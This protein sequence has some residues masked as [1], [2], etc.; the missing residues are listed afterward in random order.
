MD[1]TSIPNVAIVIAN[2]NTAH[3]VTDAIES[4]LTQD[5]PA[6]GIFIV[7]D[8]SSDESLKIIK[9]FLYKN[10]PVGIV[11][12]SGPLMEENE[13]Y[14]LQ[15][16]YLKNCRAYLFALK[17][18]VGRGQ[19][20][21]FPIAWALNNGY[22]LIQILDSDDIMMENKVSTLVKVMLNDP[23]HIG[24]VYADYFIYN[25]DN[26]VTTYE[27]KES[28]DYF[29]FYSGKDM[30]HSSSLINGA[31]LAKSGLFPP[32]QSTCEDYH[33]YRRILK[34][35]VAIG[36]AT[37]LTVVRSH[38]LDSTNSIRSEEWNYNFQK[39]MRET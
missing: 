6:K 27:S 20:R 38:S 22:H 13:H 21:N 3:F 17:R 29:N 34:W 2:Y 30:V 7:D 11:M 10:G 25:V 31:A 28:Y 18:N 37:P 32:D 9:D 4:A 16:F 19:V 23:Q 33:L 1:Q 14:V 35:F 39:T 15:E 5:Y 24:I 8:C 26:N 12:D 36:I